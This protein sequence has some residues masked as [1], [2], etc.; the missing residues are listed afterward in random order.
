MAGVRIKNSLLLL[1]PP[2]FRGCLNQIRESYLQ[3]F[4]Y[5]AQPVSIWGRSPL[6][7]ALVTFPGVHPLYLLGC[8]LCIS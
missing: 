7:M 4:P 1:V 8:I 3:G 6:Y 5:A 2:D